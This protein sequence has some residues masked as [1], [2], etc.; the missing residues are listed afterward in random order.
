MA[1]VGWLRRGLSLALWASAVCLGGTGG[2]EEQKMFV[3]VSPR[4]PRYLEL[5]DG[6]PYVPIGLNAVGPDR[7]GMAD[8]ERWLKALSENGGNFCRIWLSNGFFDAEHVRSGQYDPEKAKRIEELLALA[9]RHGIRLKLCLEHFRH[10]SDQPAWCGKR[11]HLVSQ[12]GPAASIADFFDGERPREQFKRKLA[13]FAERFGSDPTVFGWELWNEVD[14]VA[15]GDWM[16]WSEVM[17]AELHRL[18]PKSLAMQSLGSFDTAG[19]RE[20][21]RRHSLLPGNDVAQVHRYLDLGASLAVCRGPMDVLA[22]DAVREL[23]S[24][25]PRRPILLAESGAVE[26]SHS[27]PFKLYEKDK[28]GILLHDV[29]FAPFFAGAAGPG[30][31]WHWNVYVD[32]LNLWHHFGRFAEAIRGIDPPAEAFEPIE[33]Q[34]DPLRI[35]ALKGRKTFL[36]WCRDRED[37]WEAELRDAKPPRRLSGITLDFSAHLPAADKL[38]ARIYDPWTNQWTSREADRGRL[39]L[40]DFSRSLIFRVELQRP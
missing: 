20:R 23:R 8:Y 33:L 18:F 14:C 31:I 13:W 24:H 38:P 22:A 17:L 36:A 37:T 27:G 19:K 40:P 7:G 12:G 25:E 34:H 10:L 6:S 21:Y 30:H 32:K 9:R 35:L 29:L 5:S 11:L 1:E 16:A 39:T 2:A 28:A 3:R 15:G 4:D 26:P